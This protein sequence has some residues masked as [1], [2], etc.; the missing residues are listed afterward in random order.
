MELRFTFG[1]HSLE[2]LE[3]HRAT[4]EEFGY[5]CTTEVCHVGR[6]ELHTLVAI[7]P[8]KENPIVFTRAQ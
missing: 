4:L 3:R 6:H 1:I 8:K 5:A 2:L 7:E